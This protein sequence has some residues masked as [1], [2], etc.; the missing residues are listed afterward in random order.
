MKDCH[1]FNNNILFSYFT[2]QFKIWSMFQLGLEGYSNK[3]H[4]LLEK[5]VEKMVNFKVDPLRFDI[6][7]ENVVSLCMASCYL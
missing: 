3:Q 1:D 6:L 5:L 4:V 7:K 2:L